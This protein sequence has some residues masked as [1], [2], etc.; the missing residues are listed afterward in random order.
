M[1]R[2]ITKVG[3]SEAVQNTWSGAVLL[4]LFKKG[5]MRAC[6]NYRGISLIVVAA[7]V[8][9]V[10]IFKYSNSRGTSALA[11]IKVALGLDMGARIECTTYNAHW[12]SVGAPSRL[13]LCASLIFFP[14]SIP[15]IRTL[16][17]PSTAWACRMIVKAC[18]FICV[19]RSGLEGS[20][21]VKDNMIAV[22][23]GMTCWWAV[24]WFCLY[25]YRGKSL[26][27]GKGA[28]TEKR[29]GCGTNERLY[30]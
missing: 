17:G 11:Q 23:C 9:G 10:I 28:K 1:P 19:L 18:M 20:R 12:S 4:P 6:S 13:L 16:Y 26:G 5:G 14:R 8:F 7:R 3:L 24:K 2:V 30:N 27:M 29:D 25:I 15:W 22:R 21:W